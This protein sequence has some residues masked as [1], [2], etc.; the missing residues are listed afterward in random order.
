MIAEKGLGVNISNNL[1][2]KTPAGQSPVL[3][4]TG[5]LDSVWAE[6]KHKNIYNRGQFLVIVRFLLTE[7]S[8]SGKFVGCF[9]SLQ[10]ALGGEL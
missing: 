10:S 2:I 9:D 1:K 5:P 6:S 7:H 4:R 3:L 8:F